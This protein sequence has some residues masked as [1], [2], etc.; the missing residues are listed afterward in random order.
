MKKWLLLICLFSVAACNSDKKKAVTQH[1]LKQIL[2]ERFDIYNGDIENQRYTGNIVETYDPDGNNIKTQYVS[3]SGGIVMQFAHSYKNGNKVKTEWIDD[4]EFMVR[5]TINSFDENGNME[6]SQTLD[7]MDRFE[8]GFKSRWSNDGKI[9]E[10]GP[11][12]AGS[13][14]VPSGIVHYNDKDD[15][16]KSEEYG[17]NGELRKTISYEYL[18]HNDEG[19]WVERKEYSNNTLVRIEKRRFIY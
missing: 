16:I 13:N 5:Y 6:R 3:V 8:S 2:S 10:R 7:N 9:E 11:Y 14:F 1:Y 17:Q 19:K 4:S 18:S 15:P 12:N